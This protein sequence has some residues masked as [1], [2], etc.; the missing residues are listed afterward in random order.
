MNDVIKQKAIDLAKSIAE[1]EEY[2]EFVSTE[3]VLKQDELAQSLL[4]EFQ[5]KQQEFVSKQLMGEMDE[6]L[7]DSLTNLQ[8]RLNELD[9]V[10]NFMEAYTKLV[11][12][13]GEVGDLISQELD[14]DFGEVYR[15]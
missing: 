10:K 12:L 11:N 14:F 7:L 6:A 13:L 5:E 9:S 4:I 2:L 8:N 3:E 15:G 1:S